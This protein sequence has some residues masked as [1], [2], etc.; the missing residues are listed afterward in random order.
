MKKLSVAALILFFVAA[1]TT[2][3]LAYK[4][5]AI[6]ESDIPQNIDDD[7]K[8]TIKYLYVS[9][10]E[11]QAQAVDHIGELGDGAAEAVPFLM[12]MMEDT[13]ISGKVV[14]ALIKIGT[15]SVDP[16]I[17]K[18]KHDS[19]I[20]RLSAAETLGE[21]RDP[22]AVQPLISTLKDE[23]TGVQRVSIVALGQIADR[24]AVPVLVSILESNNTELCKL[25]AIALGNIG[26]QRAVKALTRSLEDNSSVV[27]L[28][29]IRALNKIGHRYPEE[30]LLIALNDPTKE[31]RLAAV[32]ALAD[33]YRVS[34]RIK[35]AVYTL[36]AGSPIQQ[37]EAGQD[38]AYMKKD[39]EP[40]I[41][42][43]IEFLN[44][45]QYAIAEILDVFKNMPVKS[46]KPLLASLK[47]ENSTR[48]KNA[49]IALGEI[50]DLGLVE[51]IIEMST[52][53]NEEVRNAALDVIVKLGKHKKNG[54]K[55]VKLYIVKYLKDRRTQ[56]RIFAIKAAGRIGNLKILNPTIR[57]LD[58]FDEDVRLAAAE[59]LTGLES[60]AI[61]EILLS[62]INDSSWKVRLK[63]IEV[64][65]VRKHMEAC[66]YFITALD[67]VSE[68][69]S[70][71]AAKALG[72]LDYKDCT[73]Y[74]FKYLDD[75][76]FRFRSQVMDTLEKLT[77]ANIGQNV[78]EWKNWQTDYYFLL[79]SSAVNPV[80]LRAMAAEQLGEMDDV[81]LIE[82]L[83]MSLSVNKKSQVR[84]K[85]LKALRD[86]TGE[87]L[88]EKAFDWK[89]W[90]MS[91]LILGT[92]SVYLTVRINC[93]VKAGNL[94]N[95]H[96]VKYMIPLLEDPDPLIRNSC[97]KSLHQITGKN[98]GLDY[99]AW[100]KWYRLRGKF[101]YDP[102]A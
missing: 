61:N 57:A 29:A 40:A 1:I 52:D 90:W 47:H 91:G 48:R 56:V 25:S 34:S 62:S 5:P 31:V 41:P 49:V 58:D 4:K 18:L 93:I 53:D 3:S 63:I 87:D 67:D 60:N 36:Y 16:L 71:G 33:I 97:A 77:E 11:H 22:K 69:V 76:N 54:D 46:R 28:N 20:V 85:L 94:R 13:R 21:I 19:W 12:D 80:T 27:R 79:L 38:L 2:A 17:K 64:L 84:E 50:A 75:T 82:P 81:S 6:P 8:E 73:I 68:E 66:P 95:G 72:T 15:P 24:A 98:F 89:E 30:Q 14:N 55:V 74:L 44:E 9:N 78:L 51:T 99:D 45:D 92:K 10:E 86:L 35:D 32:D 96:A 101:L 39:A 83:I 42:L 43:L 59:A 88:G 23:N 26:D 70:V 100:D 7:L 102:D 65:T 37:V